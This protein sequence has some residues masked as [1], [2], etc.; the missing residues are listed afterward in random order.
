M[1]TLSY[2]AVAGPRE[3]RKERVLWATFESCVEGNAIS[4][5]S[6]WVGMGNHLLYWTSTQQTSFLSVSRRWVMA[7][8]WLLS[9]SSLALQRDTQSGLCRSAQNEHV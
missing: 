8:Q 6:L 1:S 4:L 5:L 2:Q 3:E 9:C 7:V